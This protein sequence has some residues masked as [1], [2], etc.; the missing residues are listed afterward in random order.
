MTQVEHLCYSRRMEGS[1]FNI[2]LQACTAHRMSSYFFSASGPSVKIYSVVTGRIVSTLHPPQHSSASDAGS[3]TRDS[4][5][6]M[7]LNPHNS[8]QLI[9]GALDGIV[10]VWDF[11]D[12]VLLKAFNVG[13][14]VHHL[15]V[16]ERFKDEVYISVARPARRVNKN[17]VSS[18]ILTFEFH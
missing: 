7:A 8:F 6:C 2:L 4:V 1:V 15:A 10:R 5:T 11:V 13:K 3:A 14:P 12:G 16:H 18:F 9:T 17:G